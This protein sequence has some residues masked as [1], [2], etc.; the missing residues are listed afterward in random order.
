MLKLIT[1]DPDYED[2]R[3][4]SEEYWAK[5]LPKKMPLHD[6]LVVPLLEWINHGKPTELSGIVVAGAL[7]T[8]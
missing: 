8:S 7:V 4:I 6:I 1:C 2:A 5:T 3:F